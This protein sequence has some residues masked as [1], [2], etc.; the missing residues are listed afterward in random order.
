MQQVFFAN[1]NKHLKWDQMILGICEKIIS[2]IVNPGDLV[3]VKLHMGER[4]GGTF[5]KPSLVK[6]IVDFIKNIGGEPF[7]TDTSTLYRR[8]R[9]NAIEYLKTALMNGFSPEFIGCPIIIADG[10]NGESE[11]EVSFNGKYLKKVYVASTFM[12]VD[13][14]I[15]VSHGKGHRLCGFGGSIKNVGMGCLSQK[16][17]I[18]IHKVSQP[19]VNVEKCVGCR[20][21]E[22]QCRWNA[23]KVIDNVAKISYEKCVGCLDCFIVC[24]FEAV[25]PPEEG[26][27]Q[28]LVRLAEAAAAVL[29]KFKNKAVFINFLIDITELCD[30]VP[31]ASRK[32]APDIGIL[33]SKDI[34][35]IDKASIDL[36]KENCNNKNIFLDLHKIDPEIMIKTGEEVK[37]GSA[38]YKLVEI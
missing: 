13:S 33:G 6:P 5:L 20:I 12:S 28:V 27:E 38:N 26:K 14:L 3:A 22:K 30:C 31:N 7:L 32:F 1:L 29:K 18:L 8:G 17:K 4:G 9:G 24:S 15:V 11:V 25:S 23:I 34:V 19:N 2:S 16:G 10:L 37:L 21:C 36:I 35:A